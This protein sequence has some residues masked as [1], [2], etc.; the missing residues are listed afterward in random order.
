MKPHHLIATCLILASA[1]LHA[2]KKPEPIEPKSDELKAVFTTKPESKPASITKA[3]TTAKPGDTLTLKG[4]VMG[5]AKPF[6]DG[7]SIFILG[8]DKTLTP[9]NERPGDNCTAPWD[10][11][12]DTP[13]TIKQG[14]A[15]IQVLDARGR[16]LKEGIE[17]VKG[18][19][20]LSQVIVTGKVAPGSSTELLLIN[21]TA[22]EVK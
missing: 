5:N 17:N 4:R 21:A 22:I 10:N 3:R 12:C 9:C 13:E 14:T 2:E 16:V 15:T 7:R 1:V 6:V 8:D 20:K 19:T 18:L 11:C